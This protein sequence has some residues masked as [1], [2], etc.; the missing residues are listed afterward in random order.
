VWTRPANA[1]PGIPPC[2]QGQLG[3][4][5]WPPHRARRVVRHGKT[6]DRTAGGPCRF[7]GITLVDLQTL[8][9]K[10]K[11]GGWSPA[12]RR[13]CG[14]GLPA[15]GPGQS[16][17]VKVCI[18]DKSDDRR[19]GA[20][21]MRLAVGPT[22]WTFDASSQRPSR[23]RGAANR[24]TRLYSLVNKP[25][26]EP[27]LGATPSGWAYVGFLPSDEDLKAIR[28]T[29]IRVILAGPRVVKKETDYRTQGAAGADANRTDYSGSPG[30]TSTRARRACS[31][32]PAESSRSDKG[33]ARRSA[34]AKET[35]G[36]PC[37][38]RAARQCLY[39]PRNA[40]IQRAQVEGLVLGPTTAFRRQERLPQPPTSRRR[41]EGHE[42][43]RE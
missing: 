24:G 2:L 41:I 15:A 25:V 27:G 37:G 20:D 26:D 4:E 17:D 30:D 33:A 1:L 14:R 8:D 19:V 12:D 9:A 13:R 36:T 35:R 16:Q 39:Q 42:R 5:P 28:V 38:R 11:C 21:E 31:W 6:P 43:L 7:A 40:A 32:P 18:E 29:K 10:A 34:T 23:R 22:C 3:F